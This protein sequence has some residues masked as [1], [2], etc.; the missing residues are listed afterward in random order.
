MHEISYLFNMCHSANSICSWS[1]PKC[2]VI[3]LWIIRLDK[4]MR[5][6]MHGDIVALAHLC[7][8]LHFFSTKC[9]ENMRC[10][11][12]CIIYSIRSQLS[13]HLKSI[14]NT[15]VIDRRQIEVNNT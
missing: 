7:H 2:V 3:L 13:K 14:F 1:I 12:L 9:D 4:H 8:F 5:L 10:K 15:I 6:P 11:F